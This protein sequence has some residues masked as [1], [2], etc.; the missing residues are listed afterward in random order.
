M[1]KIQ[2]F[3]IARNGHTV[4]AL[5]PPALRPSK[6]APMPEATHSV[7]LFFEVAGY[8]KAQATGRGHNAADAARNLAD[9]I[10][11]TRA[12][13]ETP[14][15]PPSREERLSALL[16]CGLRKAVAKQDYDRVCR[17]SKAAALVLSGAVEPTA[18]PAVLAVRSQEHPETW[19]EVESGKCTCPDSQKHVR[20]GEKYLCKHSL[21][22]AMVA[23][24]EADN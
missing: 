11:A 22:T 1:Q 8:G 24:L 12:A 21:A 19:Y 23:K 18:S 5:V 14:P 9:T 13:L 16:A 15:P 17:L 6:P 7:N 20:N 4:P 10:R 3:T 2:R